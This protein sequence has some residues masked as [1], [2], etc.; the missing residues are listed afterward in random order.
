MIETNN[1]FKYCI[2]TMPKRDDLQYYYMSEG[3]G[4]FGVKKIWRTGLY[5]FYLA[6]KQKVEI[7]IFFSAADENSGLIYYAF[8]DSIKIDETEKN[9]FRTTYSFHDLTEI[10]EP[11][12]KS[13]LKL[14]STD[15]PLSDNY[16]RPYAICQTPDFIIDLDQEKGLAP[17][18]NS[19]K[20]GSEKFHL[21]GREADFSLSDFWQWSSS[22]VVSNSIRGIL[23][24]FI[25]AQS[26]NLAN[27]LRSP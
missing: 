21:N 14:R 22:D 20:K 13:S 11:K 8:L 5:L 10:K 15:N 23:A 6:K 16:I 9:V 26:L 7:P 2:Y 24:E 18:K 4:D 1:Y 3:S 25:V 12:P 19:R 17:I 27:T